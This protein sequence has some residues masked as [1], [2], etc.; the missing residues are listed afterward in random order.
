MVDK[1]K[2]NHEGTIRRRLLKPGSKDG[3]KKKYLNAFDQF[4]WR[5][6]EALPSWIKRR[7]SP[8]GKG[9]RKKQ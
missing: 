2:K 6:R 7:L 1:I 4:P 5:R 9:S 8:C 3:G